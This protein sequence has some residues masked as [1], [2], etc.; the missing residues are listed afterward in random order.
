LIPFTLISNGLLS[1]PEVAAALAVASSA[2]ESAPLSSVEIDALLLVCL[3]FLRKASI[4]HM[5]L[6]STSEVTGTT[7]SRWLHAEDAEEEDVEDCV[8]ERRLLPGN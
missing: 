2:P 5:Y 8:L 3:A 4:G 7:T 1:S 6:N